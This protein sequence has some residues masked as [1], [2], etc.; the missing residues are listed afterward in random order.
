L[1]A[2]M[3]RGTGLSQ[4]REAF[5][6]SRGRAPRGE[7][8]SQK[9][10]RAAMNAK[11]GGNACRR[12]RGHYPAPFGAPPPPYLLGRSL[13]LAVKQSS[14]AKT[15]PRERESIFRSRKR[16]RMKKSAARTGL[17]CFTLPWRAGVRKASRGTHNRLE[18]W[19]I[20]RACRVPIGV[21][22]G[23]ESRSCRQW[24]QRPV[25]GGRANRGSLF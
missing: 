17:V 9:G 19:P 1:S 10:T 11:T 25:G 13:F 21:K 22:A 6:E 7:R 14:G 20:K 2:T 16:G 15:A 3:K 8:V 23:V 18:K 4:G 5:G 24:R 12:A